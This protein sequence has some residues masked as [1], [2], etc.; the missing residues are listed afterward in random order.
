[1]GS[2]IKTICC[3]DCGSNFTFSAEEKEFFQSWGYNSEPKRCPSCRQAR[4]LEQYRN[5]S[6]NHGTHL[7]MSRATCTDCGKDTEVPFEPRAGRPVYCPNCY[8]KVR[9][10]VD[11][12]I[13]A[14]ATASAY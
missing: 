2:Q 9:G 6:Y 5:G 11:R 4:K 3:S 12:C 14:I 10:L 13:T 1:M 8:H 7:H